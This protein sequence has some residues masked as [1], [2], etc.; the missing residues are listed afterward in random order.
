MQEKGRR[1]KEVW[2]NG[3]LI[4][5][6]KPEVRGRQNPLGDLRNNEVAARKG[7]RGEKEERRPGARVTQELDY[8]RIPLLI[9]KN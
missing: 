1:V 3:C 9:V 6:T 7:L 8:P 2:V 5:S 4:S